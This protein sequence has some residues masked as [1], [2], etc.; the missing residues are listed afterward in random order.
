MKQ[1]YQVKEQAAGEKRLMLMWY[2]YKLFGK[3][4]INFIAFFVTFFTFLFAAEIRGYSKKYLKII[5][6]YTGLK[7]SLINQFRH[8]LSYSHV[9][10]DR[11]EIFSGS[12][13][14]NKLVFN[15][16]SDK[17]EL[18]ADFAA[19]RGVFFLCAHTGNTDAMRIFFINNTESTNIKVNVFFSKTQ[20]QVFNSF[21][22]KISKDV[23]ITPYDVEDIGIQTSITLKDSLDNGDIAFIAGDR[24][25]ENSNA[26][27][28]EAKLFGHKVDFPVG[29][30]KLAELMEAKIYFVIALKEK[31]DKYKIYLENHKF[32]TLSD[33]ENAYVKFLEKI[34]LLAPLQFYHF[35]DIFK[36]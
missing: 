10:T 25:A 16:E 35:Y 33:L 13:D 1:W 6:P 31:H 19:H 21:I 17:Q 22:K 28:F 36:D 30:F 27:T 23:P 26:S 32:T 5:Y 34:T 2:I 29:S 18:F 7:P 9:L 20:S 24:I 15:S 3:K 4:T 14:K 8:F 11:I 12:F